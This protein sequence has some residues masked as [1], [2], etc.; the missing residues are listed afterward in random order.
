MSYGT[1]YQIDQF[2]VV[3][4]AVSPAKTLSQPTVG[5]RIFEQHSFGAMKALLISSRNTDITNRGCCSC[6]A[7]WQTQYSELKYSP[8]DWIVKGWPLNHKWPQ[9]AS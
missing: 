8:V 1:E 9:P 7:C 2:V 5:G 4:A 6:L 3:C